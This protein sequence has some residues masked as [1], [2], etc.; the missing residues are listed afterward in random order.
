MQDVLDKLLTYF[1]DAQC[2]ELLCNGPH[3]LWLV[4]ARGMRAGPAPFTDDL[5]MAEWVQDFA[6]S[7]G[8]RLDPQCGSAGG[9]LGEEFRWHC[10]LPPLARDGPLFSLRRHRFAHL[11][12]ASFAGH[13]QYAERLSTI[14]QARHNL[15]VVGPTG[16]GKTSLLVALLSAHARTERVLCVE[17][18]PEFPRLH[19]AWVR[20]VERP[21]SIEGQ[22]AVAM[23]RLVGEALR[24]RPDRLVIG[25]IRGREAASFVEAAMTGHGGTYATMHAGSVPEALRRLAYLARELGPLAVETIDGTHGS[26]L[27]IVVMERGHPPRIAG[28]AAAAH[29]A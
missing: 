22:G 13:A 20:L 18:T 4:D 2:D 25:E 27:E 8:A 15:L 1:S 14:M 24:L 5:S 3:T 7:Q 9:L 12:L 10:V 16:S 29:F 21:A 26:P 11:D 28:C 23:P 17:S 6:W 19:P